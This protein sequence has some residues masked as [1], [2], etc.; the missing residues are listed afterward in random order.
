[1]EKFCSHCGKKLKEEADICL[2]C[3][4]LVNKGENTSQKQL[5]KKI[6][7]NGISIAG[8]VLGIVAAVW[9]FFDI[10]AIGGIPS[11]LSELQYNTSYYVSLTY[12]YFWFGIG[13]TLFSLIPSMVGLPLSIVG[14]KKNKNA[15]NIVGLILNIIALSVSI[16]MMVYILSFA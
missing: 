13:Y 1:M 6:P 3:G 11:S 8:M 2:N 10:M 4:V 16:I 5:K 12:L 9:S 7:G 14:L 15:K